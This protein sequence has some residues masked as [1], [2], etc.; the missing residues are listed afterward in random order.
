[1][2]QPVRRATQQ[3]A[4]AILELS[5]RF[6][7]GSPYGHLLAFNPDALESL[8][9]FTLERGAVFL[10]EVDGAPV[11]FL[12]GMVVHN[13]ISG[14]LMAE[15]F[16][17]WVNPEQ[18]GGRLA[19]Y[20]LRSFEEWAGQMGSVCLK[21]V[22]PAG[23]DVGRFYA[24]LGYTPLETAFI[25]RLSHGTTQQEASARQRRP[26]QVPEGEAGST[27]GDP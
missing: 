14:E 6:L 13:P 22:A 8:I 21:M 25:K 19:Y 18:R 20:I 15:E 10:A 3:D 1:M 17:W 27:E 11:G 12:A 9:A 26:I 4:G 23:S 16:A 24:R 7:A 5:R 2:T